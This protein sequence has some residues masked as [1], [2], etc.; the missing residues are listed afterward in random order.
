MTAPEEMSSQLLA[1][2]MQYHASHAG[3][4]WCV[5]KAEVRR[6]CQR[7][8]ASVCLGRGEQGAVPRTRQRCVDVKHHGRDYFGVHRRRACIGDVVAHADIALKTREGVRE[9]GGRDAPFEL[10]K[11]LVVLRNEVLYEADHD[12]VRRCPTLTKQ[13]RA[14]LGGRGAST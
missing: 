10:E 13:S 12:F 7:T 6:R 4:R 9:R 11:K 1:V 14:H 8:S 3:R 2:L 5:S